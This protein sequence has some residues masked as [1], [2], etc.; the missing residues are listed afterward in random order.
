MSTTADSPSKPT[1]PAPGTSPEAVVTATNKPQ[2][3]SDPKPTNQPDSPHDP[4]PP[5]NTK[6]PNNEHSS[7]RPNNNPPK[8]PPRSSTFNDPPNGDPP[9]GQTPTLGPVTAPTAIEFTRTTPIP[10]SSGQAANS[11]P[12]LPIMSAGGS[13]IYVDPSDPNAIVV[14]IPSSPGSQTLSA[15]GPPIV[16]SG[17][18]ISIAPTGGAVIMSGQSNLVPLGTMGDQ[19]IWMDP[20]QPGV[21]LIGDP[22]SPEAL[23]TLGTS[24]DSLA[25]ISGTTISLARPTG[26]AMTP[27]AMSIMGLS[28]S[29]DPAS[30]TLKI[31][32]EHILQPGSPQISIKGHTVFFDPR[33]E[34]VVID[35]VSYPLV[36]LPSIVVVHD[37]GTST[38]RLDGNAAAVT[39]A[40]SEPLKVSDA[41]STAPSNSRNT[42]TTRTEGESFASD[43]AGTTSTP[44]ET[45][46]PGSASRQGFSSWLCA[47][48]LLLLLRVMTV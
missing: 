44:A 34:N 41:A 42:D 23:K 43:G 37:G 35:G 46:K 32:G 9:H 30:R 31:D 47:S 48:V 4:N 6:S 26:S 2:S 20:L 13:P 12:N 15:G 33:G 1:D 7:A 16:V 14:G 17:T 19:T 45:S 10:E 27:V 18:T 28:L 22:S 25:V 3:S 24:S 29:L 40:S 11:R 38:L 21:L 8:D 36:G 5:Q 39:S